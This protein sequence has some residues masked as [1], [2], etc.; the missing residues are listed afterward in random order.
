MRDSRSHLHSALRVGTCGHT[1]KEMADVCSRPMNGYFHCGSFPSEWNGSLSMLKNQFYQTVALLISTATFPNVIYACGWGN[2]LV[3]RE[4]HQSANQ[5]T[6]MSVQRVYN[7][8]KILIIHLKRGL[9]FYCKC[10][11][12]LVIR[13]PSL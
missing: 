12:A 3:S 2:L 9:I 5:L 6:P 8:I 11:V 7:A 10:Q 13:I 4:G 1:E